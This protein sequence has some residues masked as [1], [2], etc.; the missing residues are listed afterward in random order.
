MSLKIKLILA[1]VVTL[2]LTFALKQLYDSIWEAG[3]NAAKKE[4]QAQV[5][6][7]KDKQS[8]KNVALSKDSNTIAATIK[9]NKQQAHKEIDNVA[10]GIQEAID[11]VD[12]KQPL[13]AIDGFEGEEITPLVLTKEF[14]DMW[15]SLNKIGNRNFEG[16]YD[17]AY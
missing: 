8:D 14:V 11:Y 9:K 2:A 10:K 12:I 5:D 16:N 6:N 15:N 7:L 1:F 4:D 17:A 3:F 13:Y